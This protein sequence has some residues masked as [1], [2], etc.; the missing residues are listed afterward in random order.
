MDSEKN[1]T[2]NNFARRGGRRKACPPR[3]RVST[4]TAS[5]S[6]EAAAPSH[7]SGEVPPALKTEQG[8]PTSN[9]DTRRLTKNRRRIERLSGGSYEAVRAR[10]QD[11]RRRGH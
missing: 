4:S 2:Q 6:E 9:F 11:T 1:G 3:I 5:N 10:Q 7:G 8:T